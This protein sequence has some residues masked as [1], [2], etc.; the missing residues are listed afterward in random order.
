MFYVY[1]L[2]SLIADK[3]YIGQSI[4]AEA[5]LKIHNGNHAR[6]TKR[7]QPWKIVY[8]E[9]CPTRGMAMKRE[10]ELKSV[11]DIKSFLNKIKGNQE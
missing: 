1:I 4:D 7:F 9:E 5:R 8:K 2:E 3:H 6:W 10:K 11:K